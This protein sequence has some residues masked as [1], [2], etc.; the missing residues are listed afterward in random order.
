MNAP[1]F[2]PVCAGVG[3]VEVGRREAR[4][5]IRCP[6]CCGSGYDPIDEGLW[7]RV[8]TDGREVPQK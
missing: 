2:C 6:C 1:T 8:D 3:E 7:D 5:W 4:E